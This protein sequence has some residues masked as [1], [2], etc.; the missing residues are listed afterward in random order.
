M[1][2][3]LLASFFVLLLGFG[4]L[5]FPFLTKDRSN[6]LA[7]FEGPKLTKLNFKEVAFENTSD[8]TKLAGMLF[9]PKGEGPFPVAVFVHGSGT[10]QRDNP[11]YLA[12]VKE[13]Q[14][15]GVA[16]L[17][18]DKRGSEKSEGDWIG[19]PVEELATDTESAVEYIRSQKLFDYS[20]IGLIGVSQGGWIAPVVAARSDQLSFVVNISGSVTSGEE[21]L[22]F[23]ERNNIAK[24]TYDFLAP[25]I[26]Q[27]TTGNLKTKKSVMPFLDFD[28]TNYWKKV[29]TPEFI[30]Y[31]END[32][33]CPVELS[34]KKIKQAGLND[35][36]VEVYPDG[37]HALLDESKKG[38]SKAFMDDLKQ[39]VR[40][41]V[42]E[43]REQFRRQ[44]KSQG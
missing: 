17:L 22:L 27:I 15:Y 8:K 2:N 31:G 23:E 43:S 36:K 34:L 9:L 32:T 42:S 39:F 26:A 14:D 4:L 19:K 30:A 28:P 44:P 25:G 21:Q 3:I 10:S 6:P 5:L 38:I 20:G 12:I 33:N 1:R 13:L 16:V 24:Y 37:R 11:W 29:K 40:Q 41:S 35:I 7:K 18:P